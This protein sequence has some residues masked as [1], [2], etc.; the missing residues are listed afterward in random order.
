MYIYTYMYISISEKE[1][2]HLKDTKKKYMGRF[3]ERKGKGKMILL[4]YNLKHL[5]AVLRKLNR[6]LLM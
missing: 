4:Y 2:K 1:A 5:K 6:I 3:R